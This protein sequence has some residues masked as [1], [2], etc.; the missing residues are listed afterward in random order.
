MLFRETQNQAERNGP[1]REHGPIHVVTDN[2]DTGTQMLAPRTEPSQPRES[3]VL[4]DQEIHS[5]CPHI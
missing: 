3:Q 1:I 5:H 2:M 4:L